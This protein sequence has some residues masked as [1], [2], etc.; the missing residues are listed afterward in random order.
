MSKK[1]GNQTVFFQQPVSIIAAASIVGPKEGQGPIGK[2]FDRVV[3][4]VLWD[5]KSWEQAESKFV[6]D[7]IKLAIQK[8]GLL[9]TEIDCI[10]A[11]DLLNQIIGT[12]FGVRDLNRPFIGMFGAC[13]TFGLAMGVGSMLVDGGFYNNVIASASSHFCAAEK[14]FRFPLEFGSQ[15]PPSST[16][17]VTGNGAA[18][19]SNKT[20]GKGICVTAY[21]AGKVVDM[22]ITDINNMGAAMAPSAADTLITHFKDTGRNP[23]YYDLIITG[24]LGYIGHELVLKITQEQGYHI[25]SNYTDCGIKIFDR[26]TQDTHSG[27]SGCA[28]SAVTFAGYLYNQM[29]NSAIGKLL[30]LPTGALLSTTSAQQ[31]ES[32]PGICHAVAIENIS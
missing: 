11:G 3:E 32:I 31:G 22:G 19:L 1:H 9:D 17:T 14:Q 10:L 21:T 28:C 27:G 8:S 30:L 29:Q 7:A 4:D 12:S 15:R 24:D 20:G 25:S 18:V 23:D 26:E 5:C 6:S 16:W 13:S 2:Y